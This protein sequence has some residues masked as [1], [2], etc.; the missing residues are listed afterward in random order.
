MKQ[1]TPFKQFLYK[2]F[3]GQKVINGKHNK[4]SNLLF[5]EQQH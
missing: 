4:L 1:G 5:T 3:I 2:N